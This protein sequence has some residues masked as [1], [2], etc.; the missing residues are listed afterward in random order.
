MIIYTFALLIPWGGT[1]P[2]M[3]SASENDFTENTFCK[4]DDYIALRELYLS[5]DGDNWAARTNWP[6]ATFFNMNPTRPFGLDIDDEDWYGVTTNMNGCVIE[7]RLF[8]NDLNGTIPPEIGL[9]TN[10]ICLQLHN[11]QLSGSIPPEF[12]NLINLETLSLY[13]N[14]FSGCYEENLMTLCTQLDA[15]SN[16]NNAI[17]RNNTFDASWEDFCNNGT[18]LCICTTSLF[19]TNNIP[20]TTYQAGNDIISNGTVPTGNNV[21][22]KAGQFIF[23]DNDF[24]VEPNA[25]FSAEIDDCG[26]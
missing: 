25:N 1:S 11:N 18:G 20:S 4:D 19:I 7:L 13:T 26:N 3:V 5:T 8:S 17:S 24:T 10:L 9:M 22:F 21:Q 23:L 6:N 14:Q 16:T 15:T 2:T 12:G